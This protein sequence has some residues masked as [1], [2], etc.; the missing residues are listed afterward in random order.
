[1]T[2]PEMSGDEEILVGSVKPLECGAVVHGCLRRQQRF[3]KLC[4]FDFVEH[5]YIPIKFAVLPMF[6]GLH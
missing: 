6:G 3:E 1:M 4:W 5:F 2:L